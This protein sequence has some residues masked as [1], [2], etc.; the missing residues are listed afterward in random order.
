MGKSLILIP[1]S[2]VENWMHLSTQFCPFEWQWDYKTLNRKRA[3][4]TLCLM[5]HLHFTAYRYNL[6]TMSASTGSTDDTDTQ[7]LEKALVSSWEHEVY[8]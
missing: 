6:G 4:A 7:L 1:R 8:H 3:V 2:E 5:F